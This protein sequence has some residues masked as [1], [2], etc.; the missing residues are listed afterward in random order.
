MISRLIFGAKV[1]ARNEKRETRK[2]SMPTTDRRGGQIFP[3]EKKE[4]LSRIIEWSNTKAADV[5]GGISSS[6]F[7]AE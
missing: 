2:R 6:K 4:K 3:R 1:G 5:G 7:C